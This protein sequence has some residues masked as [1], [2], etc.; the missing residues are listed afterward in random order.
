MNLDLNDKAV[1]KEWIKVVK[2]YLK[3]ELRKKPRII[4]I[5]DEEVL[6]EKLE[7]VYTRVAGTT[8]DTGKNWG[9]RKTTPS[10]AQVN[11]I[12]RAFPEVDEAARL[13]MEDPKE[14]ELQAL[15]SELEAERRQ[16]EEYKKQFHEK[17]SQLEKERQLQVKTIERLTK[18]LEG[19]G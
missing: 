7:D 1:R 15:R 13:A 19:D 8:L 10:M 5:G 2:D 3:V 18:M 12:R 14:A 6:I 9:P 4:K 16:H 17:I 11:A